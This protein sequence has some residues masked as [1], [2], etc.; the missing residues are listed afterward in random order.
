MLPHCQRAYEQVVLLHVRRQT[1]HGV[2]GDGYAINSSPT[3]HL[4]VGQRSEHE[5]VQERRFAGATGTHDGQ[6]LSGM[7]HSAHCQGKQTLNTV[8]RFTSFI[9]RH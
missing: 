9:Q 6:Q 2:A 5:R 7:R 8:N 4:E 3:A 1:G